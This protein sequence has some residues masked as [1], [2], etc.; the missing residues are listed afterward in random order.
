MV[1]NSCSLNIFLIF[2]VGSTRAPFYTEWQ[3][4]EACNQLRN[5]LK[6]PPP[7]GVTPPWAR[8]RM[9]YLGRPLASKTAKVG[10]TVYLNCLFVFFLD[11]FPREGPRSNQPASQPASQPGQFNQT[12]PTQVKE[13]GNA[14]YNSASSDNVA[15]Q[16]PEPPGWRLLDRCARL[17]LF[18]FQVGGA[19]GPLFWGYGGKPR[20]FLSL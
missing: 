17:G 18:N 19:A 1:L 15:I 10:F 2:W 14:A 13:S 16:G 3:T 5:L 12:L 20:G 8:Y 9:T 6:A 7:V 4:L 11:R